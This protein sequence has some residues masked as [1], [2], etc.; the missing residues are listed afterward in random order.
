M[1]E[2]YKQARNAAWKTLLQC[3][4]D[5][6]P[7]NLT[8]VSEVYHIPILCFSDIQ[9]VAAGLSEFSG[10]GFSA[11][12]NGSCIIYLNDQIH[13]RP[14]RRFTVAHELGHIILGHPL[15]TIQHRN[16]ETDAGQ[17]PAEMQANVFARDLLMPACVL[18]ALNIHAPEEIMKLCD[19]SYTSACIRVERLEELYTRGKFGVHPLERQVIRQFAQFIK[20]REKK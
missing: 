3:K 20:E 1:Y 8:T 7:V 14:R 4:I 5:S 2:L 16:S 11:N 12:I 17:P 18:A 19:I 9:P 13:H 6:L 15:D 10:D